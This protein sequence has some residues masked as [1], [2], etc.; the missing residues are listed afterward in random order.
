MAKLEEWR[1]QCTVSD[2]CLTSLDLTVE[3]REKLLFYHELQ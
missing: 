3:W 1:F 2:F